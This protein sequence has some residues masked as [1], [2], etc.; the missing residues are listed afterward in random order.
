MI[1][2]SETGLGER[3]RYEYNC[4]VHVQSSTEINPSSPASQI[5]DLQDPFL[6]GPFYR[7]V[8][9]RG[10]FIIIVGFGSHSFFFFRCV[11][12]CPLHSPHWKGYGGVGA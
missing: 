12:D 4:G 9:K 10:E 5:F 3:S 7:A 1:I 8:H 11:S 2:A 6:I